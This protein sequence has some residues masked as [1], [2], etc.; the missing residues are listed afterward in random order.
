MAP[1]Q[2]LIARERT[3]AT[4]TDAELVERCI[5]GDQQAWEQLVKR[6][7]RLVYSVAVSVCRETEVAADVLQQVCLELYQH[8]DEIRKVDDLRPWLVTVTRRKAISYLRSLKPTLPIVDD[9][10]FVE[11]TDLVAR[12]EQQYMLEQALSTLSERD[13]RMLELL[14]AGRTYDEVAAELDMPVASIG[15]TRIRCLNK[16]RSRLTK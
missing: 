1:L 7:Q 12:V 15:P 4:F 9:E 6:Y 2:L 5:R 3:K 11:P 14:S 10:Q 16:L 8:L 13:R